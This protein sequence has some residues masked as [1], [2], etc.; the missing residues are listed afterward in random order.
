MMIIKSTRLGQLEIEDNEI[1]VFPKG[2]PGFTHE[3][4]FVILPCEVNSPFAF[5]QSVIE[6]DLTF[7]IV[8]PFSFF[9]DYEFSLD[10][11]VLEALQLSDDNRPQIF[12]IVTVPERTEDMTANLLAPVII[13]PL[14]RLAQQIVLE[15]TPYTTR[16][17]LFPNGFP[18][19]ESKGGR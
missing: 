18:K 10:E 9:K 13:N 1:I 11:Q 14:G 15:K 4:Q 16:H 2:L 7:L 5:M 6:P 3:K 19:M 17:R 8:E 12:N